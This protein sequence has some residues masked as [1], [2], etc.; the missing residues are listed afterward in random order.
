MASNVHNIIDGSDIGRSRK[1]KS[2]LQV[3][4]DPLTTIF[5]FGHTHTLVT[6]SS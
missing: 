2:V 6:A 5:N 1:S 4:A 3:S